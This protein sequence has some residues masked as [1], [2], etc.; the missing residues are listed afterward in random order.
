MGSGGDKCLT[1]VEESVLK[2]LGG[3]NR[4]LQ[5]WI[6]VLLL[7]IPKYS[8]VYFNFILFLFRKQE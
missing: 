5:N 6:A 7:F 3:G 8:S 2:K 4:C 1:L